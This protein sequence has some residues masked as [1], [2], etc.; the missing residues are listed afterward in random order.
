MKIPKSFFTIGVVA[1]FIVAVPIMIVGANFFI[2]KSNDL[3]H[4]CL[5]VKKY[6]VSLPCDE[7]AMPALEPFVNFLGFLIMLTT[8]YALYLIHDRFRN[9]L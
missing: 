3:L 6:L 9:Y 1:A 2:L 5:F 8:A 7:I 4:N